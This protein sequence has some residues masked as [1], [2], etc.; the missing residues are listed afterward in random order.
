MK[1]M[2]M[3]LLAAALL[4]CAGCAMA[5]GWQT[6]PTVDS[7]GDITLK[8]GTPYQLPDGSDAAI[9]GD[10]KIAPGAAVKLHLNGRTLTCSGVVVPEGATL[11][12]IDSQEGT[13][14]IVCS[15]NAW[16]V[17]IEEGSMTMDGGTITANGG[18]AAAVYVS[19]GGTFT[20]NKGTLSGTQEGVS[21]NGSFTME[22]G[23]VTGKWGVR[24]HATFMMEDG[25]V[26]GKAGDGVDN[27][28]SFTMHGGTVEATGSG[29]CGVTGGTFTMHGGHVKGVTNGVD[30]N[31]AF[32]ISAGTIESKN[33]KSVTKVTEEHSVL[34]G[35]Y[36]RRGAFE[37]NLV[38]VEKSPAAE[39]QL[40]GGTGMP[41]GGGAPDAGSLPQTGDASM[42]GAWIALLGASAMGLRIRKRR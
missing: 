15:Y 7:N 2:L 12:L 32:R 28:G 4:L 36:V 3:A 26:T 10:V 18:S 35:S 13:G 1:K 16:G 30:T 34:P 33:G 27:S 8:A 31:G 38:I 22:G 20:L 19:G 21:N 25:T 37:E 39:P 24:N 11:E 23:T 6:M 14:K 40:P 9:T 5:D 17:W 29:G 41:G 42:L